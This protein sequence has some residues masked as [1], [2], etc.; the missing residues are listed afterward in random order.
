MRPKDFVWIHDYHLSLVPRLIRE[1]AKKARLAF[2][3]H[4]PWVPWEIFSNLPWRRELLE[5]LLG[6]D[7]IGFQTKTFVENFLKCVQKEFGIPVKAGKGLIKFL[8]REVRVGAFPIGIDYDRFTDLSRAVLDQTERVKR[9]HRG[10]HILLSIDRLDYSKGIPNRLEAFER[11]LEKYPYFRGEVVFLMVATPSRTKIA[12][13]RTIKEKVDRQVGHINSKFRRVD[14][15][16][17]HYFHRTLSQSELLSFYRAAD[18]ALITPL[19]DGMNLISKE[20]VAASENGVIILSEFAGASEQLK[21]AILVN[22]QDIEKLAG[23]IKFALKMP[24]KERRRRSKLL[25]RKVKK[26]DAYW[27]LTRFFEEWKNNYLF[28]C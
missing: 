18:V 21:E 23:A 13:Y 6:A 14:W 28:S 4:I 27:W 17:V 26:F 10:K 16:P 20:Y 19:M 3:W 11:F 1:K 5:G 7:L 12:E 2:F 22:P 15:V 8:G 25:K 24:L 9:I